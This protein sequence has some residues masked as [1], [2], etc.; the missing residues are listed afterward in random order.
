MF[1]LDNS[2]LNLSENSCFFEPNN[3]LDIIYKQSIVLSPKERYLQI[4]NIKNGYIEA[5]YV[6]RIETC[7]GKLVDISNFVRLQTFLDSKGFKQ[8]V[9]EIA[10]LN[11]DFKNELV[12]LNFEN[13]YYSNWFLITEK[14]DTF[15]LDYK[16]YKNYKGIDYENAQYMQSI[17]LQGVYKGAT[18]ETEGNIYTELNGNIRKSRVIQKLKHS[19][20]CE[21]L[22]I[23]TLERLLYALN[24]DVCYINGIRSKIID[25]L[26]G[27]DFINQKTNILK[28]EFVT[29]LDYEDNFLD[30]YQLFDELQV[31]SYYPNGVFPV[32]GLP[33]NFEVNFNYNISGIAP[34]Q[35]YK[36][37]FLYGN[38]TGTILNYKILFNFAP[39]LDEIGIFQFIMPNG[40]VF[41]NLGSSTGFNISVIVKNNQYNSLHYNKNQFL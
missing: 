21:F 9:I 20:S 3:V 23:F 34:I 19:F 38:I 17:R 10:P 29:F 13:Y 18:T 33:S 37:S 2:F 1:S 12:R 14:K 8:I 24:S 11:L 36:N 26:K 35:V 40:Y 39:A 6:I 25:D 28:S 31:I 41:N 30:N 7:S 27:S 22:D 5:D 16:S 15:R 4:S 32:N